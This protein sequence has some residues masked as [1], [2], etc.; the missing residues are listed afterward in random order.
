MPAYHM[1]LT[2]LSPV[3]IGSGEEIDPITEVSGVQGRLNN[4]GFDCGKVTGRMNEPTAAA[5]REFQ[6]E[7]GLEVT[8]QM[9][10]ET[11]DKLEETYNS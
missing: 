10:Q 1:T 3:H 5:I 7:Y 8:G 4:I 11:K 9:D 2:M 6:R